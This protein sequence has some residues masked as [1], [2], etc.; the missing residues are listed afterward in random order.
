V[1]HVGVA[2]ALATVVFVWGSMV[3]ADEARGTAA[4]LFRAGSTAFARGEYRAAALAYEEADRRLPHPMTLC[5]AGFAWDR[6]G[7]PARAADAFHGALERG[8][9]A[10]PQASDAAR[11]LAELERDLGAIEVSVTGGGEVTVAHAVR[12]PAPVRIHLATGTH[13]VRIDHPD[14]RRSKKRVRVSAGQVTPLTVAAPVP[15]PTRVA[16]VPEPAPAADASPVLPVLGWV[17]LGL[18]STALGTG[19]YLGVRGLE[20]RDDFVAS[21]QTDGG[22]REEAITL[23]TWANVAFGTAVVTGGVGVTLLIVSATSS[24]PRAG[25]ASGATSMGLSARGAF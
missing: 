18:A 7:E 14:G 3:K 1:S 4:E 16:V 17:A 24:E 12:R 11:R 5:N 19:I 8:G 13:E 23:R 6:A 20:A 2:A 10:E 22:L 15:V 25:A 21:G 9:L